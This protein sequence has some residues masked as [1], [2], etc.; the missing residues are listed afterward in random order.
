MTWT[1]KRCEA[2]YEPY[3]GSR[4]CPACADRNCVDCGVSLTTRRADI[5]R[6]DQCK[7][8]WVLLRA[9]TWYG[10]NKDRR[11]AYDK[12]R[13]AAQ[14]HLYRDASKRWRNNHPLNKKADTDSRRRRVRHAMPPWVDKAEIKG[15]YLCA[16]QKT[17]DTGV[18]WHVDHIVPLRGRNVSG[19]HVP[20]NLQIIL[21]TENL[22]KR[23]HYSL[24]HN[25]AQ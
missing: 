3:S 5:E 17:V 16:K 2:Q 18:K 13:R 24:E 25:G 1:C 20:W 15:I 14:G 22:K 19:L 12:T 9:S 8:Q 4:I 23:N 10:D 7:Q 11:R 21:A 6:C